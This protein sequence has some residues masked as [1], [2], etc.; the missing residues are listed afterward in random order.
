MIMNSNNLELPFLRV[1]ARKITWRR[2]NAAHAFSIEEG[3]RSMA[4]N[5]PISA[6]LTPQKEEREKKKVCSG[7]LYKMVRNHI[8]EYYGKLK[9]QTA[10]QN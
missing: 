3:F 5:L 2:A 9:N 4:T 8:H 7:L 1:S 10:L 6:P